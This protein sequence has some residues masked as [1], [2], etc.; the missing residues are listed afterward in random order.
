MRVLLGIG[1]RDDSLRALD[2][3]VERAVEAGDDLTVAV[4]DDPEADRTVD[5]LID[6]T[7]ARLADADLAAEVRRVEGHPGS[8]LV[9]MAERDDFDR[10]VLGGGESSPMGKI[11]LGDVTEFVLLNS[12][13]TVTLVR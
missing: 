9:E 7:T 6:R 2:E 4:V 10:I 3:A 5:D 8:E 12:R 11:R 13:V 1:G